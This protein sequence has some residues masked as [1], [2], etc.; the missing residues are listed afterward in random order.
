MSTGLGLPGTIISRSIS[1]GPRNTTRS[2]LPN[3]LPPS[4]GIGCTA[5]PEGRCS[6]YTISSSSKVLTS[7]NLPS[8]RMHM[9]LLWRNG[10]FLGSSGRAFFAS[11]VRNTKRP[12]PS[13]RWGNHSSANDVT[14][15][16]NPW[17]IKA[18]LTQP[19]KYFHAM[20]TGT[21]IC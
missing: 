11:P 15:I 7:L 4:V 16:P 20:R 8:T 13:V 19:R 12:N 21:S 2:C 14:S 3:N 10:Q 9:F 17:H 5:G 6:H 1:A 18:T